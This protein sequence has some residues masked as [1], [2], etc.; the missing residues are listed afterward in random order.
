MINLIIYIYIYQLYLSGSIK[1]P[2]LVLLRHQTSWLLRSHTKQDETVISWRFS[3]PWRSGALCGHR[4]PRLSKRS[5]KKG[6]PSRWQD[7]LS[8]RH[9][10]SDECVD[11]ANF[12]D[13]FLRLSFGSNERKG[14]GTFFGCSMVHGTW[15]GF[16]SG[17]KGWM[18]KHTQ[19]LQDTKWDT[20][21]KIQMSPQ[22]RDHF[23]KD[24]NHWFSEIFLFFGG[25]IL[26]T[27]RW[28][29]NILGCLGNTFFSNGDKLHGLTKGQYK[30]KHFT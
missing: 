30:K 16:A 11:D 26:W 7:E 27:I 15:R 1:S 5:K 24:S 9:C 8:R 17:S 6:D 25:V 21:L 4:I 13:C 18:K 23:K 19:K 28:L 14:K 29:P 22:R 2:L 10:N 12:D 20:P 3:K